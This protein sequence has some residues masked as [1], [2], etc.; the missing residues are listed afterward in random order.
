MRKDDLNTD[1]LKTNDNENSTKRG[2]KRR[3]IILLIGVCI[4]VFAYFYIGH[5][6]LRIITTN[7]K[8]SNVRCSRD[9]IDAI[10]VSVGRYGKRSDNN[11]NTYSCYHSSLNYGLYFY[12]FDLEVNGKV[13][14]PEIRVFHTQSGEHT[15]TLIKV[16]VIKNG[17]RY[18]ANVFVQMNNLSIQQSF[19]DI[20]NQPIELQLGP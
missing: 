11:I 4:G 2:S 13:I 1:A 3:L 18:D 9:N 8:L 14:T 17:D 5:T 10:D 15:G 16:D 7:C 20:E 19:E 12:T 6:Q